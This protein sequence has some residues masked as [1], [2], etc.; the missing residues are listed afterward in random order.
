MN[1]MHNPPHPGEL[2]KSTLLDSTGLNVTEGAALLGVTRGSLSKLINCRGGL[3]PEMAMRLSIALNTSAEMW[4]NLQTNY[5]L[6]V[7]EK[8]R[9][10]LKHEVSRVTKTSIAHCKMSRKTFKTKSK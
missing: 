7:I 8:V 6:S 4:L 5:D 10:K 9:N 1:R 3:S 2:V